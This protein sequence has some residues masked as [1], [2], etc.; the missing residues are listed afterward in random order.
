MITAPTSTDT[1]AGPPAADT[2]LLRTP[3]DTAFRATPDS[4][5][6]AAGDSLGRFI[7][8]DSLAGADSLAWGDLALI[9]TL[10]PPEPDFRPASAYEV[11]G[12]SS[13]AV[14]SVPTIHQEPRQP[15]T[16]NPF[17][18]AAVLLFAA[19]YATLLY[20]H[21]TD[22]RL[23]LSRVFH[24]R[25]SG[26][27]LAEE[28]GSSGLARFLK[29]ADIIGLCFIGVAAAKF[30]DELFAPDDFPELPLPLTLCVSLVFALLWLAIVAFQTLLLRAAGLL[31]LNRPLIDQLRLLKRTYFAL[32]VIVAAPPFLLFALTPPDQGFGWFCTAA[33]M[34]AVT[35]LLYLRESR[36]LFVAKKIPFLHWF[37]YLCAVE[38]F[39]FSFL[40]L[41]AVR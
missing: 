3:R 8:P 15:L 35:A 12:S 39:P 33:G 29:I 36:L 31:T 11:F 5:A 4:A 24:N 23:L 27:R 22:V 26:E 30:V 7:L 6:L 38:I 28:P 21:M 18:Q 13:I 1:L 37:L 34:L 20:R 17:F 14:V 32:A 10:P 25:A 16:G 40:W 2:V 9:D 41:T 19:A